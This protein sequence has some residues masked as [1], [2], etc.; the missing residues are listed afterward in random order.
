MIEAELLKVLEDEKVYISEEKQRKLM[1]N[2][3]VKCMFIGIFADVKKNHASV[4]GFNSSSDAPYKDIS[5]KKEEIVESGVLS[6]EFHG[7]MNGR[8]MQLLIMTPERVKTIITD[9]HYSP[10]FHFEEQYSV[11]ISLSPNKIDKL[12][13]SM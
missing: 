13:D 9:I 4:I 11:S 6:I 12:A 7:L 1:D 3:L 8:I 2:Q 10:L 5:V